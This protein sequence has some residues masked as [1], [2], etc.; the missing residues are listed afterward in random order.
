MYGEVF[1]AEGTGLAG[2]LV[3]SCSSE[4]EG[5]AGLMMFCLGSGEGRGMG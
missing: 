2:W 1:L 4:M 5:V 3:R